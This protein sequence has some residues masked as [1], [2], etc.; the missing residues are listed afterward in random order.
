MHWH[1]HPDL[2][3]L[4]ASWQQESNDPVSIWQHPMLDAFIESGCDYLPLGSLHYHKTQ[5][6]YIG[7]PDL[8][9]IADRNLNSKRDLLSLQQRTSITSLWET[10]VLVKDDFWPNM[11]AMYMGGGLIADF[12]MQRHE[13]ASFSFKGQ[14]EGC[15]RIMMD[16]RRIPGRRASDKRNCMVSGRF[17]PFFANPFS[18][19]A[20]SELGICTVSLVALD[21][22]RDEVEMMDETLGPFL[23]TWSVFKFLRGTGPD[24]KSVIWS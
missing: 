18:G 19:I 23:K 13:I 3:A 10:P 6:G 8:T 15:E 12:D 21:G 24:N 16:F 11:E 7:R 20:S 5:G 22:G 2:R 4:Q 17:L 9:Y 1:E 14:N